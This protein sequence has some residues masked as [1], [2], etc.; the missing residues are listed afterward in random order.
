MRLKKQN[1]EPRDFISWPQLKTFM[2]RER[3][4][5]LLQESQVPFHIIERTIRIVLKDG[6][7]TFSTLAWIG[8]VHSIENFI[9]ADHYRGLLD[10]RLHMSKEMLTSVLCSEEKSRL[11]FREQW[12]FLAPVLQL[13]QAHRRLDNHTIL[14]FTESHNLSAGATGAFSEM[15]KVTVDA[16]HHRIPHTGEKVRPLRTHHEEFITNYIA[17]I[18]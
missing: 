3:V 7:K 8:V 16:D 17:K 12:M 13:D 6:I 2:T 18:A 15:S 9:E 5:R 14:P 4:L 10:A 1:F 11:F